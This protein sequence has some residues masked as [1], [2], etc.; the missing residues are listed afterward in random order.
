[1]SAMHPDGTPRM[2]ESKCLACGYTFD[3]ASGVTGAEH[4]Q[5]GDI[6]L[7]LRCG[8]LM[9]FNADLTTRALTDAEM[10]EVA[11]DPRILEVQRARKHV[12]KDKRQ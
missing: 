12:M 10:L 4:P 3:A 8:H 9:A 1:M 5:A 7:C 11:E 6:S 2:P